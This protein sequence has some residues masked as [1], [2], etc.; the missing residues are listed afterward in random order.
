MRA[1]WPRLMGLLV[2]FAGVCLGAGWDASVWGAGGDGVALSA[3]PQGEHWPSSNRPASDP[4]PQGVQP[5]QFLLQPPAEL[6]AQPPLVPLPESQKRIQVGPRSNALIHIK[7]YPG[8]APNQSVTVFSNGIR[9]V[10]EGLEAQ[11]VGNLG[12]VVIETDRL[13]LWAPNLMTLS[14]SGSEATGAPELPIEV[15]LEGNIVFRQGDRL[16]YADRM[17]Y[18]ATHEY[19]V[20]LSG[21][22]FTPVRDFHGM[23][24]LKADVLQQFNRQSFEA[25]GAAI[26][27]SQMGV[28]NYWLQSE[29]LSFRDVHRPRIDPLT[30]QPEWDD[31]TKE[32]AIDHD[33]LVTS[34]NNFLYVGGLP[35]L[36]WPVMATNLR[37]PAYYLER[38]SIKNDNVLGTQVL[39]DWDLF[40]LLQIRN[41]PDGTDWLL[42]ADYLHRRGV[43]LGTTVSYLRDG[44]LG[45]PGPATG[46]FDAWGIRDKGL[47]D[48]GANRRSIDPGTDWRGRAYWRHRHEL[49]DG[50][51]VTAKFGWVSD[52]NFLEQYFEKEWDEWADRV[53]N[54]EL[55]RTWGDQS[56]RVQG[57]VRTHDYVTQTD[58][59]PRA[60]HFLLGRSILWDRVTWHA[61]SQASYARIGLI[62]PPTDPVELAQWQ[63]LPWEQPGLA[64]EGGRFAT[65]HE[66]SLP[67]QLGPV[68]VAPYALGELA[69][70]GEVLDGEQGITRGYGQAGVR[71]SVPIWRAYPTVQSL[72]WNLQGMAH[73]ITLQAD[74]YWADA[75]EDLDQ[76][77]LYDP[78]DDDSQEHF[79][80]FLGPLDPR[81]DPRNFA[82]RSGVQRWVSSPSVEMAED[83]LAA[84]LGI[85][86]RWQTKRGLPGRERVI[87][88]IVL[89]IE[90]TLYPNSDRDNFGETLGQL[91]YD[92][93][94]HV[95]DRVTILSDA[96][97]DLFNAGLRAISLGTAISRPE[98]GQLYGGITSM[99]GPFSSTVLVGAISY[100]L[101]EKWI[102]DISGTYDLGTTGNIGERLAITRVGESA[103][104]RL[105]VYADHGRDNF[106]AAVLVE[107]RFLP[108]GR[109][110]RLAG[111]PIPPA[112]AYGLE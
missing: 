6:S 76:F 19:G 43:G 21:E 61:H 63:Y 47:D 44:F 34:H 79:R 65:R 11:T 33:L 3:A 75:S 69:Y 31:R 90:G 12:R 97:A 92:F 55:R 1:A 71:M 106:G 46:W 49:P 29:R 89:D 104:I 10:I 57:Q 14:P 109:L 38:F 45:Q 67:A 39:T 73:K 9:A 86:Q 103:L 53:T 68:K 77:P 99:E 95:G 4:G 18:N 100:R 28:P 74:L 36:Y 37:K 26:T 94:W 102:T 24:R 98:R 93:R 40:Q 15:Y 54:L 78:L 111:V 58:W 7:S 70:W 32:T 52:R 42:S 13:V 84:R 80:R 62:E 20:V 88:W 50:W 101:S 22:V 25:Y 27:S 30:G 107:P 85:H 5:A 51:E 59:F 112:G 105:S 66:L 82:F 87:D 41:P 2:G 60:D 56:V 16:I 110:G 108:R 64:P 96:Y 91:G 72:L 48:L 35:T 8:T 23:V 17:Y 81:Y 83:V